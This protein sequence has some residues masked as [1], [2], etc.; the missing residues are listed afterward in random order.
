[1]FY[2]INFCLLI[3]MPLNHGWTVNIP[4]GNDA[5]S[6]ACVYSYDCNGKSAY[7]GQ[8]TNCKSRLNQHYRELFDYTK[9]N[10]FV[11]KSDNTGIL[12]VF[13]DL[14]KHGGHFSHDACI[15]DRCTGSTLSLYVDYTTNDLDD[16]ETT[17]INSYNSYSNGC[18]RVQGNGDIISY[19]AGWV[20]LS[21][22][23]AVTE[24]GAWK[25]NHDASAFIEEN[26]FLILEA[27][28]LKDKG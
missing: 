16:V 10:N 14:D 6:A 3:L 8:A 18:N 19:T 22:S 13:S 2:L 21:S 25:C 7:I 17:L 1:M 12:G 9:L 4:T 5:T 28:N 24:T 15:V 11:R 23:G 27:P 20:K 26:N